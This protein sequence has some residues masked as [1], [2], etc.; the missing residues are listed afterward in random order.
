MPKAKTGNLNVNF[1]VTNA[2]T[3]SLC[4]ED[5]TGKL[6]LLQQNINLEAGYSNNLLDLQNYLNGIYILKF[7]DTNGALIKTEK[8]IVNR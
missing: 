5:I 8:V 2:K 1:F 6:L 7:T 4:I 3:F